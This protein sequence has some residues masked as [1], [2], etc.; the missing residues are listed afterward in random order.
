[1]AHPRIVAIVAAVVMGP[2]LAACGSTEP[3][4]AT[5]ALPVA[6]NRPADT[7]MT[8]SAATDAPAGATTAS[9]AAA[10]TTA[11]IAASRHSPTAAEP[12]RVLLLGD[13]IMWDAGPALEAAL[14]AGGPVVVR[15]ES[16]WGFGLTRPEWRDWTT[17]WPQ[18]IA[19]LD[20]DVVIV[21]VGPHDVVSRPIDGTLRGPGDP[22]WSTWYGGL[23]DQ[24]AGALTARGASVVWLGMLWQGQPELHGAD[25]AVAALNVEIGALAARTPSVTYVDAAAALAGPDGRYLE[26]AEP[27]MRLRKPDGEHLCAEGAE[28]FA[29]AALV[30]IAEQFGLVAGATDPAWSHGLWRADGRYALDGG[31]GCT[32]ASASASATAPTFV[33]VPGSASAR[34][35]ASVPEPGLG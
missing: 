8:A 29:A 24:A 20:P 22:V 14:G 28:R 2:G 1:M 6:V 25:T 15:D 30:P 12:L 35:A 16:Y 26:L 18:Y 17:L 31:E 34:A 3:P 10:P 21:T 19:E 4:P 13:G 33:L 23:L 7:A 11:T 27:G 32:A 9:N 5:D